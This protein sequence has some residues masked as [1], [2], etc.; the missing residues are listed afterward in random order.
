MNIDP[1]ILSSVSAL[2]GALIGGGASLCAAIYTQRN[3]S[4]LQ[5]GP[6]LYWPSAYGLAGRVP[7]VA[8]IVFPT[9]DRLSP[10]E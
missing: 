1:A 3:Q 6:L 5:I 10:N 9:S 8:R 4:R 7:P 2:S